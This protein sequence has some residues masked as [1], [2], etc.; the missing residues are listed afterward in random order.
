MKACRVCERSLSPRHFATPRTYTCHDCRAEQKRAANFRRYHAPDRALEAES[1]SRYRI[2]QVYRIL[3]RH[4]PQTSLGVAE[5]LGISRRMATDTLRN[6]HLHGGCEQID[7]LQHPEHRGGWVN[8]WQAVNCWSRNPVG[9]HAM[10]DHE[11]TDTDEAHSKIIITD[12]DQAWMQKQQ[13]RAAQKA[14]F[15]NHAR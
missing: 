8:L 14:A 10:R 5:A 1:E 3:V 2:H 12:E 11:M 6:L 15:R 7:R 13:Q 4:G 9:R